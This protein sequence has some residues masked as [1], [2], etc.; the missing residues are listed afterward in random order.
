[1]FF[2]S[3]KDLS[4]NSKFRKSSNQV[5]EKKKRVKSGKWSKGWQMRLGKKTLNSLHMTIFKSISNLVN[6]CVK[7]V[8]PKDK[9]AIASVD[10]R[11]TGVVCLVMIA[12]TDIFS[13]L[14]KRTTFMLLLNII[15]RLTYPSQYCPATA[16]KPG[17]IAHPFTARCIAFIAEF[18]MY[19]VW[20]VW[21]G[22]EFWGSTKLWLMVRST[23]R[24]THSI[25]KQK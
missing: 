15:V 17:I 1:M 21:I 20:A 7:G 19:E 14:Q 12:M 5:R 18:C 8:R 10:W 24:I 11:F 16:S 4:T 6:E 13:P 22:V 9:N 2:E 25:I 23:D 3:L